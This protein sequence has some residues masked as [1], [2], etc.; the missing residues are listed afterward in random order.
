MLEDKGEKRRGNV[1]CI[2]PGADLGSALSNFVGIGVK[3]GEVA[4]H[5]PTCKSFNNIKKYPLELFA[6][7]QMPEEIQL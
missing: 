5:T 1:L 2:S 6:E 4:H 7:C 3:I